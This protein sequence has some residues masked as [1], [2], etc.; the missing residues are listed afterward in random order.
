MLSS[1]ILLHILLRSPKV[2]E[3]NNNH[4]KDFSQKA[5]T[6]GRSPTLILRLGKQTS[7]RQ[8]S[9]K[10]PRNSNR[11]VSEPSNTTLLV[12]PSFSGS[13]A[14]PSVSEHL[15][16]LPNISTPRQKAT[17][18]L[19]RSAAKLYQHVPQ[20]TTTSPSPKKHTPHSSISG[21]Q[22]VPPNQILKLLITQWTRLL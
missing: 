5:T 8:P 16:P 17:T 22:S 15:V 9:Q 21:Q 3:I 7:R 2:E 20:S 18:F 4:E 11:G 19:R 6:S 10:T 1:L 14:M 12:S 13:E